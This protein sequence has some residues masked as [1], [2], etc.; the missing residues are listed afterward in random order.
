MNNKLQIIKNSNPLYSN[1]NDEQILFSDYNLKYKDILSFDDYKKQMTQPI[2]FNQQNELA[3]QNMRQREALTQQDINDYLNFAEAEEMKSQGDRGFI[4]GL[5]DIKLSEAI[6]FFSS[7]IEA[8]KRYNL[9]QIINKS[10]NN[11][12]L[13]EDEQK[14]LDDYIHEQKLNKFRPYTTAGSI[15]RNS[16]SGIVNTLEFGIAAGLSAVAGVPALLTAGAITAIQP[17][18]LYNNYQARMLRGELDITDKGEVFFND[19]NKSPLKTI[20]KSLGD[21]IVSNSVELYAGKLISPLTEKLTPFFNNISKKLFNENIQRTVARMG[22]D[23]FIEE[24]WEEYI[25]KPLRLTL[26]LEDD[27]LTLQTFADSLKMSP[28][29]LLQIWGAVAIQGGTSYT[30]AILKDKLIKRGTNEQDINHV[31][32]NSTELEKEKFIKSI[33]DIETKED[34]ENYNKKLEIKK[35]QLVNAGINEQDA[36]DQLKLYDEVFIKY[37]VDL[38]V[39]RSN[40]FNKLDLEIKKQ[41]VKNNIQSQDDLVNY[42]NEFENRYNESKIFS[43]QE[44]LDFYIQYKDANRTLNNIKSKSLIQYLKENGGIYDEGQDLGKDIQK[45]IP[46]LLRK[47]RFKDGKDASIDN[48]FKRAVEAGYFPEIQD[49]RD[50]DGV[51]TLLNAI[52]EELQGNKRYNNLSDIEKV[53][54]AKDIISQIDD[55]G[56]SIDNLKKLSEFKKNKLNQEINKNIRGQIDFSNPSKAIIT[57]SE[58]ADKST[59]LHETG[60]YFLKLTEILSSE[61]KL[62]QKELQDIRKFLN[63]TGEDFTVYQIEKFARSFEA[64][65]RQGIAPN[66]KLQNIFDKFKEWLSDVYKNLSEL[67]VN[68]TPEIND[69]F[70]NYINTEFN[71][72]LE[73]QKETLQK[74][75]DNTRTELFNQG[76]SDEEIN[77]QIDKQYKERLSKIEKELLKT[78]SINENDYNSNSLIQKSNNSL[79][80]RVYNNISDFGKSIKEI[81]TDLFTNADSILYNN[82][83]EVWGKVMQ[84]QAYIDIIKS[85]YFKRIENWYKTTI[86]IKKNNKDDYYNLDFALKNRDINKIQEITEKYNLYNDYLEVRSILDELRDKAIESGID[87][88]YIENYFP[89]QIQ[90]SKL[91][92]FLLLLRENDLGLYNDLNYNLSLLEKENKVFTDEDRIKIINSYLNGYTPKM[93][94]GSVIANLKKPREIVTLTPEYNSFYEESNKALENYISS[95]SKS[96][97]LRNSIGKESLEVSKLRNEL[98]RKN[99]QI[100]DIKNTEAGKIKKN[101]IIKLETR[102]KISE[103][104][105]ENLQK[106]KEQTE[107]TQTKIK[108]IQE[109]IKSISDSLEFNRKVKSETVKKNRISQ[110]QKEIDNIK[111]QLPEETTLENSI[112]QYV[113]KIENLDIEQQKQLRELLTY[114]FNPVSTGKLNK[115]LMNSSYSLALN[116]FKNALNQLPE[117]A[118]TFYKNGFYTSIE[119]INNKKIDLKDLGINTSDMFQDSFQLTDTIMKLTGFNALDTFSK[120]VFINANL[121]KIKELIKN[122]DKDF[123]DRL[124]LIFDKQSEQVKDDILNDNFTVDVRSAI[125]INLGEVQPIFMSSRPLQ[126]LKNPSTR[127]MYSLKTFTLKQLDFIKNEII[128]KFKSNPKEAFINLVAY[129]GYLMLI[130]FPIDYIQGIMAGDEPDD[131]D[132]IKDSILDN[133]L[134]FNLIGRYM[135]TKIKN[136][137]IGKS[138]IDYIISLPVFGAVDDITKDITKIIDGNFDLEKSR[139]LKYIPFGKDIKNLIKED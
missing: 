60:H 15:A 131:P 126:F 86:E 38:G 12:N 19:L 70:K 7:G 109:Q 132:L 101:E 104:N 78:Q 95:V 41:E 117:L 81:S 137:G 32:N 130:G 98:K 113:S 36:K 47:S 23:G 111:E 17:Q 72:D 114:I 14:T 96:I 88:G 21:E 59:F 92:D 58:N 5:K 3:I 74:E 22:W 123:N 54:Q 8:D 107:E 119:A 99:K 65:L 43:K 28:D 10:K 50:V 37:A 62:A 29:E 90:Q 20:V 33:N 11:I 55:T 91:N 69:F 56:I 75:I 27:K 16:V 97:I 105:L 100:I 18:K 57:L 77:K 24:T 6:P 129:Q 40:I 1:L 116:S 136:Q 67:N 73:F 128:K 84:T 61:S 46:F 94:A 44:L 25:E 124:K 133:I 89:R 112:G 127:F 102:K 63:N 79:F 31:I 82:Y 115:I 64:Y 71:Q 108:D 35:Q 120:N 121:I 52:S 68:I 49:Y 53:Q 122:N 45:E 9:N 93:M 110:I 87:V 30:S 42:I 4:Q 138:T 134:L 76:L 106:I 2:T 103:V 66:S 80:N 39:S 85:D 13:S 139:A 34:I 48:Q 135:V 125:L 51:N 26:G 118:N 83:K